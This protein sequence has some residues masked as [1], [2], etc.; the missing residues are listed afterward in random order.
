MKRIE[1]IENIEIRSGLDIIEIINRMNIVYIIDKIEI[2]ENMMGYIYRF[3]NVSRPCAFCTLSN[4]QLYLI[5]ILLSSLYRRFHS[6][7]FPPSL[8]FSLISY[9]ILI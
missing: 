3:L 1:I 4:V 2:V 7:T 6:L 5:N 9:I 8:I